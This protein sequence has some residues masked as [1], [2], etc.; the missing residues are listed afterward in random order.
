MAHYDLFVIGGGSGGVAA[1]RSSAA[2]G[3]KVGIA[4]GDK[5]GGTCVNRGCMPK[6]W[7][8]YA[9]MCS[10]E[11]EAAKSYGWNIKDPSFCWQTLKKNTF[12]EIKRLNGIYDTML[13]Q[14]G[15]DIYQDYARFVDEKTVLV[16][17][18]KVTAD[19]FMIAVGGKPFIPDMQ[20]AEFAITSDDAFHLEELPKS[21][22]IIGAGY[23]GVEFASIFNSLGV[24]TQ[25]M[26]RAGEVLR[27]FDADVRQHMMKELEKKGIEMVP[28]T[29]PVTLSKQGH[30]QI[31]LRCDHEKDWD[32][33]QVMFTTGRVSH[34]DYLNLDATSVQLNERNK[35]IVD[36]WQQTS[37][38]HI[39]AV[40]DITNTNLDL[41]PVAINEGRAF[42][43]THFGNNKRN[44]SDFITPT[45]VFSQPP[46]GTVGLT[47][48]QA[49]EQYQ[50]I[51][52]YRTTFQPTKYRLSDTLNEE[53]LIKL[54]VDA[55][56]DK[57][58]GAHMVGP[59]A[60]EIIQILGV[61]LRS[62]ATK[63]EFDRT[64]GV[65]PTLAEEF[66]TMRE[67]V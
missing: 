45:A 34:L 58:V 60:G 52:I 7:Y 51:E 8:M 62:G 10:T 17:D 31:R 64:V 61:A 27:G 26:F 55:D 47:E 29:K 57:V 16:G 54:V 43:D 67:K 14:A 18:Q 63:Y 20:G 36:E 4:E 28:A 38:D 19:K 25:L 32:V 40:G 48:E 5:F 30:N 15:V 41:T 42:A 21:I 37:V 22:L 13:N 23:I 6:K 50:N 11:L 49:R 35:I 65:H 46:I 33:E 9:S 59:E 53:L 56:S 24:K 39:Y 44:F 1:A 66:C 3:A 12:K 2:L